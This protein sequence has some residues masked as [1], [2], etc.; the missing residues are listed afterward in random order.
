MKINDAFADMSEDFRRKATECK[1][2]EELEALLK[3]ENVEVNV[4]QLKAMAG[5]NMQ[6]ILCN[7]V[8]KE[9]F[10]MRI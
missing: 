5:D 9:S 3:A 4:E 7:R 2:F 6:E 10:C 1:N 8:L